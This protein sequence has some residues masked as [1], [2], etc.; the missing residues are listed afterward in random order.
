M[1]DRCKCHRTRFTREIESTRVK[2]VI[3]VQ[4]VLSI[5][6]SVVHVDGGRFMH[7]CTCRRVRLR[8]LIENK[9]IRVNQFR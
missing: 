2:V 8:Q 3:L 1:R 6:R 5:Y 4:V 9:R 7:V